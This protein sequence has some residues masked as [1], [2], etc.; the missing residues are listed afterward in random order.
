MSE[1]MT[2]NAFLSGL[3]LIT[4]IIY[5]PPSLATVESPVVQGLGGATRAGVPREAVFS[6]PASVVNVSH[7]FSFFHYQIPKIPDFNAGGRAFNVGMYDGGSNTWKGGFA[8]TR[9]SKATVVNKRQSYLDRSD[10][11]FSTGHNLFGSIDGGFATRWTSTPE[12]QDGRR[13]F[14]FDLGILFPLFGDLRGGLTYENLLNKEDSSPATIGAGASYTLGYGINLL[15]DG[16]RLMSGTKEGERGWALAVELSLAGNFLARAGIFE[17]AYTA[18]KGWSLGAS[19][20]GPRAS[21]DYAL[22]TRGQGP[23]EKIHVLGLTLAL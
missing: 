11:R 9:T 10:F 7:T 23:K 12:I 18:V 3:F 16:Y 6:N 17:E 5:S 21:F 8:Y 15:A 22:K 13:F 19:W 2:H 1:R 14:E 20:L 4:A